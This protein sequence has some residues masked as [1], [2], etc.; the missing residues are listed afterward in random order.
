MSTTNYP[1]HYTPRWGGPGGV[2]VQ[3]TPPTAPPKRKSHKGFWIACGMIVG[4]LLLAEAVGIIYLNTLSGSQAGQVADVATRFCTDLQHQDYTAAYGLLSSRLQAQVTQAQF[5]QYEQAQ[6]RAAGPV[7][8]CKA[9]GPVDD[10]TTGATGAMSTMQI[11]RHVTYTN[12]IALVQEGNTWKIDTLPAC[13]RHQCG[14][15][16]LTIGAQSSGLSPAP[17][18]HGLDTA[19]LAVVTDFCNALGNQDYAGAYGDLSPKTQA[20]I[21]LASFTSKFQ[22][23]NATVT[24]CTPVLSTYHVATN[25]QTAT[26]LV[27]LTARINFTGQQAPASMLPSNTVSLIK[28]GKNWEIYRLA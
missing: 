28:V 10:G 23:P 21:S 20:H 24:G 7:L 6:D 22:V 11:T 19:P 16:G 17:T 3:E 2:P 4:G 25:D 13:D 14:S 9:S 26:V 18:S 8:R 27:K 15:A 1:E 12:P 5:V